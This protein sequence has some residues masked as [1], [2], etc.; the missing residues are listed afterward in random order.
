MLAAT[1]AEV[2]WGQEG[3]GGGGESVSATPLPCSSPIPSQP[4]SE[5]WRLLT[6]RVQRHYRRLRG[7]ENS[8]LA[9]PTT[10]A[11]LAAMVGSSALSNLVC[12][13]HAL[14][15][16]MPL[17]AT[18][19][20]DDVD[21]HKEGPTVDDSL[22]RPVPAVHQSNFAAGRRLTTHVTSPRQALY[23]AEEVA[24]GEAPNTLPVVTLYCKGQAVEGGRGGGEGRNPV[25]QA[26]T[27]CIL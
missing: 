13:L 22:T 14:P 2:A 12:W 16:S 7:R 25:L 15:E 3:R 20:S 4:A 6:G 26:E 8:Q 18:M 27:R 5:L 24:Y 19:T 10:Y 23:A 9:L 17:A 21:A 11:M 1:A